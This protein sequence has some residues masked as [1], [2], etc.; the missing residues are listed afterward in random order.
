MESEFSL[1]LL[2]GFIVSAKAVTHVGDGEKVVCT[3]CFIMGAG[4]NLNKITVGGTII[5]SR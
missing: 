5:F 4:Q 3:S 1:Q 2:E